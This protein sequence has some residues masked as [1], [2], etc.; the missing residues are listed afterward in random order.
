[1]MSEQEPEAIAVAVEIKEQRVYAIEGPENPPYPIQ[2]DEVT[3][4][5]VLEVKSDVDRAHKAALGIRFHGAKYNSE[6]GR[7]LRGLIRDLKESDEEPVDVFR[8]RLAALTN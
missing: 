4:D 5:G 2:M 3:G 6:D 1:M 8:N 7:E